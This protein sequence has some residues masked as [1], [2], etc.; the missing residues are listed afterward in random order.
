MKL[1]RRNYTFAELFIFRKA[2]VK[3]LLSP[4]KIINFLLVKISSFL[5][6]NKSLG[7]P[8]NILIEPTERC[9]YHCIKC[10]K[11]SEKY[12]NNIRS[13][14]RRDISF[15]HY[16]KL[17]DEIGDVLLTLRLWHYGEPF[18][19]KDIFRMIK[20]AK[21]KNI[22]VAISSNL[23]LLTEEKA[24]NLIDS[25][26]DY[27]I[28]SFDGASEQTYGL[29]HGKNYFHKV[30]NNLRRLVELKKKKKSLNP[31]IELQ[32]I[33]MKENEK[34]IEKVRELAEDLGVNKLTYLKLD[35][36]N[37][38]F[39]QIKNLSSKDDI[40]PKSKDYCFDLEEMNRINF[41]SIPWEE[42]LIRYSGAILPCAAD[43]S[44]VYQMGRLFDENNYF[45]F[46]RLWNNKDYRK[47]REAVRSDINRVKIC[48]SCL[49]RNN[50]NS[51]QESISLRKL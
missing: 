22:I 33:V 30:V 3:I 31:F 12:K 17:I 19:N 4:K 35:T 48:Y 50:I 46:K 39:R 20:Y 37:I 41:C 34:E 8:L 1:L 51:S 23:S 42:T 15:N 10:E 24:K 26:L 29:Y 25:K 9:N 14:A 28:V 45:G 40:L 32:F 38:N 27:L 18:L 36:T 11:F 16:C 21:E 47:L 6:L 7:M 44:Q 49:K 13:F 2:L 5:K 43:L